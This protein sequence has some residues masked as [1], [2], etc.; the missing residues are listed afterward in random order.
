MPK[1]SNLLFRRGILAVVLLLFPS[2]LTGC[3]ESEIHLTVNRDGSGDLELSAAAEES[4]LEWIEAATDFNLEEI[5]KAA[6]E[7]GFSPEEF[8]ENGKTGIRAS[9]HLDSLD[10]NWE[11]MSGISPAAESDFNLEKEEGFLFNTYHFAGKVS[12][13]FLS[14]NDLFDRIAIQALS[15]TS[16]VLTLPVEPVDHN[17]DR[18]S[19]GGKTLEWELRPGESKEMAVSVRVPDTVNMVMGALGIT[20]LLFGLLYVLVLRKTPVSSK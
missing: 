18:T 20:A 12:G 10:G 7:E 14:N 9:R 11:E 2:V 1:V 6:K 13:D 4:T 19:D 16:F 3:V 8:R 15:E 17:A 5:K